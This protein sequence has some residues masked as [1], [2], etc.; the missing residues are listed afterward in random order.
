MSPDRHRSPRGVNLHGSLPKVPAERAFIVT[1]G[2]PHENTDSHCSRA[3]Q[4]LDRAGFRAGA[5]TNESI[6]QIAAIA[7]LVDGLARF[8]DTPEGDTA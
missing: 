2:V 3:L 1:I 6:Q 4:A 5:T 8:D 7:E